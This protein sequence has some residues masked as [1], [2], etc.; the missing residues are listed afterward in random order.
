[1][2]TPFKTGK[3]VGYFSLNMWCGDFSINMAE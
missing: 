3:H 1:M 2:S